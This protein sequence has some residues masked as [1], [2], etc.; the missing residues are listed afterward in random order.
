M[1]KIIFF[2]SEPLYN[3]DIKRYGYSIL[4]KNKFDVC[5]YNFAPIL[6]PELYKSAKSESRYTG[7]N[8]K[9][10]FN[11]NEALL[12]ISKLDI[13]CFIVIIL[14]YNYST[15]KIFRAVTKSKLQYGLSCINVIP[16]QNIG[17][18]KIGLLYKKILNVKL[19]LVHKKILG[20]LFKY[21]YAKLLGINSPDVIITG[22]TN[23]LYSDKLY[24]A[25]DTDI[26]W[27]H[28]YDYDTYLNTINSQSLPLKSIAVFIDA[29]S[30][31]FN[32]DS[33]IP[34]ITS[35]LTVEKYYPSLCNFFDV[36]E[37]TLGLRVIIASHPKSQHARN[38]A[39]FGGREVVHGN[40]IDLIR[41]SSLVINRNSTSINFV[42]LLNKPVIFY[43]SDEIEL[44]ASTMSSQIKSMAD[45]LSKTPINIDHLGDINWHSE[46]IINNQAY[47]KYKNAYIKKNGTVDTPIWQSFADWLKVHS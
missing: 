45:T 40:T 29:P 33:L 23:S 30:P 31:M 44:S 9:I 25:D 7:D 26:L 43:T 18:N 12:E 21:K 38:P 39:Y 42:V 8:E 5:F 13:T 2:L 1:D 11:I 4:K 15:H 32:H 24:L 14:H 35:P 16:S 28:T 20:R 37:N 6:Y 27:T 19:S 3:E 36:L 47:S 17:N 22:G 41:V 34:E 46:L 10:F